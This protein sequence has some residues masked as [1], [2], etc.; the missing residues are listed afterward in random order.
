MSPEELQRLISLLEEHLRFVSDWLAGSRNITLD[1]LQ[2]H[3]CRS[4]LIQAFLAFFSLDLIKELPEE[5]RYRFAI[6][7]RKKMGEALI[8]RAQENTGMVPPAEHPGDPENQ[9]N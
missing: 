7:E 1:K 4:E 3:E 9:K 5:E 2:R 6:E 8:R